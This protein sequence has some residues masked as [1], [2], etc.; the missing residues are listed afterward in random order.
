MSEY[1]I[2]FITTPSLREAKKISSALL[3]AR[4][5]ACA[6]MIKGVESLFR[7]QGKIDKS[8]E[9]LLVLKTRRRFFPAVSKLVKDEHSYQTPEIISFPLEN[10]ASDYR[11]WLDA[12]IRKSA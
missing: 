12:S 4:L 11:R 5:V 7:W 1:C 8:K 9:V 2:I 10:I 3:E 6:N